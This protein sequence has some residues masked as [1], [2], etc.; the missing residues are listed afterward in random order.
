MC[1]N[2][3]CVLKELSRCEE[4]VYF[5]CRK[6]LIGRS[7]IGRL[8]NIFC[9][10]PRTRARTRL[11][12]CRYAARSWLVCSGQWDE[13]SR[14]PYSVMIC[15][16]R[17]S[18]YAARAVDRGF[19]ITDTAAHTL[20]CTIC[21]LD[22]SVIHWGWITI[23]HLPMKYWFST[24]VSESFHSR[25]ICLNVSKPLNSANNRFKSFSDY[26]HQVSEP[27]VSLKFRPLTGNI[28]VKRKQ[29]S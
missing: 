14:S 17:Y 16:C 19:Q 11:A 22:Y 29:P 3:F 21:S 20:V 25:T 23:K 18:S 13:I 26:S 15:A 6:G 27:V 8:C 7:Q 9:R 24:E 1:G 10:E 2:W 4:D 12:M 28:C 5:E